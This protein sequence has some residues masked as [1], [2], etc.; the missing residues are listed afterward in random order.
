VIAAIENSSFLSRLYRNFFNDHPLLPRGSKLR[1]KMVRSFKDLPD[2]D[3]WM[4]DSW[5]SAK[6]L[7]NL[8]TKAVK[9]QYIQHD[10]RMYHGDPKVVE[11][12]FRLPLI[13]FVNA[14]WLQRMLKRDFNYEAEVM[15]NSVD[16]DLFNPNKRDRRPDDGLIKILLLHHDYGWKNSKEGAQIVMELKEKYPNV[17][18]VLFGTR[19]KNIDLPHDEYHFNVFGEDLARLFANSDIFLGASIDDSR[20]LPHRWAMASG[21]ALATYDNVSSDDYAFNGE[22]SLVAEKGNREDLKNKVEELIRDSEL[23]RQVIQSAL[24]FVR[25]LPTWDEMT[26]KLENIFKKGLNQT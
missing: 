15:F 23:R 3:V 5:K 1:L 19:A 2:A 12:V 17:R 14:T 11:E 24:V 16:C 9:F 10:E 21:C 26:D 18:L 8:K 25:K 13:K 7:Y 6:K 20:P 22:N 4:A